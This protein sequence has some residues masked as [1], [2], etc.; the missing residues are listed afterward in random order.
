[1]IL[2][3]TLISGKILDDEKVIKSYDISAFIVV[4]VSKPKPSASEVGI[5]QWVF[6]NVHL[7]QHVLI[8]QNIKRIP[9]Q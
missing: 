1:M 2:N 4:M 3:W 5:W 9:F 6:R 8:S 7:S